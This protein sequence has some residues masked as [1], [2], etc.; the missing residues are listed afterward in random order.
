MTIGTSNKSYVYVGMG[1]ET[2]AGRIVD[3]GLYRMN[4]GDDDWEALTRG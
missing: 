4:E 1:G 2:A 3:T